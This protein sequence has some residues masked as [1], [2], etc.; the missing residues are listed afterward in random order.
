[1]AAAHGGA[2]SSAPQLQAAAPA[3]ASR[4]LAVARCRRGSASVGGAYSSNK[5]RNVHTVVTNST[6]LRCVRSALQQRSACAPTPDDCET[7]ESSRA[8]VTTA[9]STGS[10]GSPRERRAALSR[11]SLAIGALGTPRHATDHLHCKRHLRYWPL[12]LVGARRLKLAGGAA[13]GVWHGGQAVSGGRLT[14]WLTREARLGGILASVAGRGGAR[15]GLGRLARRSA[16]RN[17]RRH[18]LGR[19]FLVLARLHRGWLAPPSLG[20]QLGLG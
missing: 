5:N 7:R 10:S 2:I 8:E 14:R 4:R 16:L 11:G 18:R 6:D 12:V 15:C 20:L 19:G 13:L 17:R 1:M 3:D 9:F